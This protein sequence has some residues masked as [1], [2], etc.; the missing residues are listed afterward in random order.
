MKQELP[1][2]LEEK[3]HSLAHLLASAILELYSNAQITLGP[4]IDTGFYY[5]IFLST[6]LSEKD[7][8]IIQKRME[9]LLPTW[10]SFI[11]KK[12]APN[13][14]REFF[15][16]NPFKQ[17]LINEI[18]LRGEDITLY[19]SGNFTDLCRGG[20]V[21]SM[22][23]I[24]KNS[25]K[26]HRIAG[27]Y[28]RGDEKN[29]ML[30]R[31]YGLAF[32]TAE[33]LSEHLTM[34]EEA[35]KRDH[36]KLGKELDLFTFSE[37]VGPG[38]PLFTPRGTLLRD[39]IVHKIQTIQSGLGY[40]RVSIPHITKSDL[41]KTSGHWEKFGAELMRVTGGQTG[42][43]FV[44]KPMNCPHHTQIYA[45]RMRSY[46]D[47]PIRYMESTMVYRDE[48]AG[49]LLGLSRVRSITQDDGHVF[50]TPEQVLQEVRNVIHVV[51]EFYT[52]LGM[53]GDE[54][55]YWVSLSV[56]DPKTPE[57][58]LGDNDRWNKAEQILEEA[59]TLEKINFRQVEGE[60]TFYG[61][62]LDFQFYDAIKRE[63]QLATVQIDMVMPV[64]FGLEYTNSEGQKE[65]PI[66]IH[67]AI[68]GSL[69]R[70]LAIIIE[71][72]AGHFPL[73]LAP[74][75]VTILP[76]SP[77]IHGDHAQNIAHTLSQAGFRVETLN[78]NDSLGKRIRRS[79]LMKIPYILV[80]GDSEVIEKMYT[81]EGRSENKKEKR[82]LAELIERLKNEIQ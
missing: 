7:L 55:S 75:Q 10:E 2:T 57:K 60:A 58:Y 34:L 54:N 19:T 79:K 48:Q 32:D 81:L 67:R 64:R 43:E 63:R 30:T 31:I 13:E 12:V 14:A 11:E 46:R 65:T 27:A 16:G 52:A 20:H 77:E 74:T 51:R 8:G 49:E 21:S 50:C 62:K 76:V 28:W 25:F 59:A 17:E 36:R 61:P 41:Y 6:T 33:E 42:D 3:R 37:L 1:S 47:L 4:A 70:F 22:K 82:N 29:P 56:R 26:L 5:D 18:E 23:E 69:E 73:W 24:Q 45:S 72:F 9:K 68:A 15:E 39:L 38:L 53:W 80:V 40:Q 44:M 71:H 35:E 78:D 66:M